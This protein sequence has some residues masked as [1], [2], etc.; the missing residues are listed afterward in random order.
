MD[1]PRTVYQRIDATHNGPGGDEGQTYDAV[2]AGQVAHRQRRRGLVKLKVGSMLMNKVIDKMRQGWSPEQIAGRLRQM[3]PNDPSFHVSHE[4]I[5]RTIYVTPR[6]EL[7][8][9]LIS[10]LRKSHQTRLPRARGERRRS[11]ID[12]VSIHERSVEVLSRAVPGHWE[13]D[14]IKGAYNRSAVGTLVE[15]TSRFVLLAKMADAT[16]DSAL[17]AFTR[18]FRYVPAS[19]RKTLTYD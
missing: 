4:T 13:G 14:L 10:L 8:K 15:R 2:H 16:A 18:R 12:M 3:H 19:I 6:G 9:E 1:G 5:Y 17:E 11:L 7:R